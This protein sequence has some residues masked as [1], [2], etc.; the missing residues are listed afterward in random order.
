MTE[1]IPAI[2]AEIKALSDRVAALDATLGLTAS[3]GDLDTLAS[4][5]AALGKRV[6]SAAPTVTRDDLAAI[7]ERLSR[8][9]VAA[10]AGGGGGSASTAA[11]TSLAAQLADAE[12]QVKG[13]TDRVTAAESKMTTLA[14]RTAAKPRRGR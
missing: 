1:G 3:R 12:A 5:L 10:A 8:L 7:A 9:E 6:D 11:I 2:R 14:V 13:L 4:D